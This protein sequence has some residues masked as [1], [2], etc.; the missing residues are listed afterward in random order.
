MRGLR[1]ALWSVLSG[2]PCWWSAEVN[3]SL[4]IP[5]WLTVANRW[6]VESKA[7]LVTLWVVTGNGPAI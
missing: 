1:V 3:Q 5:S 2:V 6:S 7:P 4:M